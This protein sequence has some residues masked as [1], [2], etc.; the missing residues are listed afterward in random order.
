MGFVCNFK[1]KMTK[2]NDIPIIIS[3]INDPSSVKAH[4]KETFILCV[5]VINNRLKN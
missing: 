3:Q 2:V 5:M 1:Y 4:Y